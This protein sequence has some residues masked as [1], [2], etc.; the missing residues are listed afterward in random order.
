MKRMPAAGKRS[1]ASIYAEPTIPN[2]SVTPCA[3]IVSTNASLG[4][5][6]IFAVMF[7]ILSSLGRAGLA[8]AN[9]IV[10]AIRELP[11]RLKGARGHHIDDVLG[12]A[13][14]REIVHGAREPL[15]QGA[16][17]IGTGESFGDFV[18][19]VSR[20]EVREHEHVCTAGY[21]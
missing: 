4:V 20:I 3:T 17:G 6:R 7:S 16:D 14:A 2:T 1:S 21:G 5:M 11:L 12:L 13:A 19:N 8:C 15:Q 9:S 10:V 18:R